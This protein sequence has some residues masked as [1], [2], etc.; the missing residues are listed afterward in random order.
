MDKYLG[1]PRQGMCTDSPMEDIMCGRSICSTSALSPAAGP[2][3]RR[4]ATNRLEMKTW[5]GAGNGPGGFAL[6]AHSS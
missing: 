3:K 1:Y 5:A 2:A 6:R 4:A